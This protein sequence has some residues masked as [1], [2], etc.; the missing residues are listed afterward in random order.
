MNL[1]GEMDPFTTKHCMHAFHEIQPLFSINKTPSRTQ[2]DCTRIFEPSLTGSE[3]G[4]SCGSK[5][6]CGTVFQVGDG[7]QTQHPIIFYQ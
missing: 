1:I 5:D 2:E 7:L 6:E 3:Q 4:T